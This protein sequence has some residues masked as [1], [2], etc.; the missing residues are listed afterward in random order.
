MIVSIEY[1]RF[2]IGIFIGGQSARKIWVRV[3][4]TVFPRAEFQKQHVTNDDFAVILFVDNT[5]STRESRF[6]RRL[7]MSF[8]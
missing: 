2:F 8:F 4:G 6:L 3:T 7:I 1:L 5:F